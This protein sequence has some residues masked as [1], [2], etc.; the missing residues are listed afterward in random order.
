LGERDLRFVGGEVMD[1][2]WLRFTLFEIEDVNAA[3]G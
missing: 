1:P 3:G 2:S